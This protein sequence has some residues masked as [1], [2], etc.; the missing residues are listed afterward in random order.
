M[1]GPLA[2]QTMGA[3]WLYHGGLVQDRLRYFDPRQRRPG[4]PNEVAAL[5][6]EITPESVRLALVNL[7]TYEEKDVLIQGGAFAEHTFIDVQPSGDSQS[8]IPIDGNA[9]QVHLGSEAQ[10]T[11]QI[12]MKR[13]VNKPSYDFPWDRA[14]S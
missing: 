12:R 11:L 5:I 13:F 7:N 10:A 8:A 3:D 14:E 2:Q 4:L 9:F 6:E 1:P